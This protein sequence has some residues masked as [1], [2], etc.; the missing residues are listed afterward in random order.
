[1]IFYFA[2]TFLVSAYQLLLNNS[3]LSFKNVF[4]LYHVNAASE[5]YVFWLSFS[6][7]VNKFIPAVE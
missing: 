1:M 2:G 7:H 6:S 3:F 5:E 4:N